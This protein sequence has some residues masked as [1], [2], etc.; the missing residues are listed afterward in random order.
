LSSKLKELKGGMKMKKLWIMMVF[1]G[2]LVFGLGGTAGADVAEFTFE[3]INTNVQSPIS[4]YMTGIYGSQVN[5]Y[6][7]DLG[8]AGS[9]GF[10]GIGNHYLWTASNQD[11]QFEINFVTVPIT[12]LYGSTLAM[13]FSNE[14]SVDF[15]IHAYGSNFG[16]VTN[17]NANSLIYSHDWNASSNNYP[18][19]LSDIPFATPVYLLVFSDNGQ[20][21]VGIDNLKVGNGTSSVPEPLTMLLLGSGLVGLWGLRRKVKK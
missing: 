12:Q 9:G 15:S 2:V 5:V 19:T 20:H 21:D 11:G 14:G 8:T 16:N 4:T 1:V 18:I 7:T 10:G 13:V 6:G 3:G 17:P